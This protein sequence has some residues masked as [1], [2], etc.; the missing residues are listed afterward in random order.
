MKYA[1]KKKC[2]ECTIGMPPLLQ[3][4][5]HEVVTNDRRA[6][7]DSF[8]ERK[9]AVEIS[10]KV[11]CAPDGLGHP[12]DVPSARMTP[13]TRASCDGAPS[14]SLVPGVTGGIDNIRLSQVH[15]RS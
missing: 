5:V 8:S 14:A 4:R 2:D 10:S 7:D 15:R 12:C 11:C 6:G 1:K 9:G 3:G 13:W